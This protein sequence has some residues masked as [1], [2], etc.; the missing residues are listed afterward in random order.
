MPLR[1]DRGQFRIWFERQ[2]GIQ[3]VECRGE[4]IKKSSMAQH[5]RFFMRIC[6]INRSMAIPDCNE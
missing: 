2:Y 4:V 5:N 3:A 1:I 6:E